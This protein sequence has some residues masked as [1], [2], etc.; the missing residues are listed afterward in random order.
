[1]RTC[2]DGDDRLVDGLNLLLL[3]QIAREERRDQEAYC[4]EDGP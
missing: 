1:M 2:K 4:D 3:E